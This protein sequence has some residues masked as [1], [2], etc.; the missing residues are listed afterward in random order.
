MP[1]DKL[2]FT[3]QDITI[4]SGSNHIQ[5]IESSAVTETIFE[6]QEMLTG[7]IDELRF[8]TSARS[9]GEISSS[10]H[11]N[12]K[13]TDSLALYYKFNEPTGSYGANNI[14]LDSSGNGLHSTITSYATRQRNLTL[15]TPVRL[16]SPKENPVLFPDY[17]T[18]TSENVRLLTSASNYDFIN[19]NFILK[20]VPSHYIEQDS[21]QPADPTILISLTPKDLSAI[22]QTQVF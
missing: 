21:V 3:R 18:L 5:K 8:W 10:M 22:I 2:D 17:P 16:E 9:I 4:G 12:A 13:N 1:F 6:M 19:P 15:P 20:L 14:V 7:S 11:Y